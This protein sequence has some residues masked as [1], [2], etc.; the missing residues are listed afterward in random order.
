M[1]MEFLQMLPTPEELKN[2]FPVSAHIENTKKKR[3]EEISNI[4]NGKDDRLLLVI[5]P[6]RMPCRIKFLLSH[7]FTQ[8]S[9]GQSVWVTRECCTSPTLKKRRIC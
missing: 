7:V 9:R 8:T 1:K 6:C 4:F 5:G 3:D 2:Q